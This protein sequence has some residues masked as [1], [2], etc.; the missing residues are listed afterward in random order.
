M[1]FHRCYRITEKLENALRKLSFIGYEIDN[2]EVS[3]SE[4]FEDNYN[5]DK[6]LPKFYW[7]KVNGQVEKSNLYVGRE[8]KLYASERLSNSLQKILQ[9]NI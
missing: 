2:V 7:L 9:L 6:A 5:L 3:K 1:E 8:K 4:C